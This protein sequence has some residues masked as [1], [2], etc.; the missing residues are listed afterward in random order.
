[1]SWYLGNER[2]NETEEQNNFWAE[3]NYL[4]ENKGFSYEDAVTQVQKGNF[5]AEHS[6]KNT[7]FL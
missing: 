1:M 6:P 2:E 3:V 7:D 4:M 5:E